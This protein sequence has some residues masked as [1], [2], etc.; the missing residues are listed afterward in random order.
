MLPRDMR[1]Y[2]TVPSP[3]VASL[4]TLVPSQAFPHI[5]SSPVRKEKKHLLLGGGTDETANDM[6]PGMPPKARDRPTNE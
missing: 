1:E 6:P 2:P 5:P 3:A 4:E